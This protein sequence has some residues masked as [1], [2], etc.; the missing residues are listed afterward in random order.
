MKLNY[1]EIIPS[2]KCILSKILENKS[3]TKP[4]HEFVLT[5]SKNYTYQDLNTSANRLAHGLLELSISKGDKIAVLMDSSPQYLDVWFAISKIGAVEVPIN[6]AYKGEILVHILNSSDTKLIIYDK[7]YGQEIRKISQKCKK[8]E[9]FIINDKGDQYRDYPIKL[10]GLYRDN[11]GD[12]NIDINYTDTACLLYTSGTT[13]VSKGVIMNNHFLWSFGVNVAQINQIDNSDISY[14]YLPF[15][16][17]AG[18]FLLMASMLVDA[19]NVVV[20]QLSISNF[21][22]DINKYKA[23]LMVAAGGVCNMLYSQPS[24]SNDS[25][26]SLKLIY[27]VPIPTEFSNDF[28]KRFDV[29][30]IEAYGSTE[31][32]VVACSE[33]GKTPPKSFGKPLSNYEM[34]IFDEFDQP[35]SPD[36]PGEIVVRPKKP[37]IMMEGYYGLPEKTL[38][39][40]KNLWFH[41]GDQGYVDSQGWFYFLDRLTDSMRRRGENISSFEVEKIINE[42]EGVSECA[43]IGIKSDMQED[44]VKVVIVKNKEVNLTEKELLYYCVEKMPYFMVPR[45]IEFKEELPRTALTKIKKVELRREGLTSKTWDCEANGLKVTRNGIKKI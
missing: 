18:K 13:G 19:Q 44:E 29:K 37:N 30:F 31:L 14:N 11:T 24:K 2:N 45:F 27:A 10:D 4:L 12:L 41:S 15:F 32:N 3:I 33:P 16:H 39:V 5:E 20:P 43:A 42:H 40:I 38:E 21:W 28:E 25:N 34:S 8:I 36:V 17:I 26:N 1:N 9:L 35:C 7:K 23:T 6:T 22:D